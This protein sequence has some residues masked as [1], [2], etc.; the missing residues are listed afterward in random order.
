MYV[1]SHFLF[2][3]ARGSQSF[4]EI[5]I[6]T[7]STWWMCRY[8][9]YPTFSTAW[10]TNE[11]ALWVEYKNSRCLV[12]DVTTWNTRFFYARIQMLRCCWALGFIVFFLFIH[13]E[14]TPEMD[15]DQFSYS[16]VVLVKCHRIFFPGCRKTRLRIYS[17]YT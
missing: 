3:I 6:I 17:T 11:S 16:F 15:C 12:N 10:V 14:L 7:N 2:K 5:S 13:H 9:F 8:L 4:T 1:N